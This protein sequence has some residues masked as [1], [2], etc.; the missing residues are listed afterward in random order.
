M[1][2]AVT[3]SVL[4][5]AGFCAASES[6][7]SP[8]SI[9][10]YPSLVQVENG[11]GP[12]WVQ[13]CAGTIITS[14]H[15]LSAARCFSGPLFNPRLRRIRAGSSIRGRDGVVIGVESVA[16]HPSW[17]ANQHDG[18]ISVVRLSASL[19][20]G[21]GIQQGSVIGQGVAIPAALAVV[22]AG[23]GSTAQDAIWANRDLHSLSMHTVD[24]AACAEAYGSISIGEIE[25]PIHITE[26]MI[27]SGLVEDDGAL[28]HGV[29]DAGGPVYYEGVL[30][31]VVT[32]GI[33]VVDRLPLV[34]TNVASFTDWIVA[35][36]V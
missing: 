36:A 23:W 8:A 11:A 10:D 28:S 25:L 35:H 33:P 20:Y 26:N 22:H 1:V 16:N 21:A 5:F 2:S 12:L 13:T 4:L 32:M 24:H 7:G 30:I 34:S 17:G 9:E 29:R 15:I 19:V 31:G 14:R 6:G 27:C 3:L 18:D